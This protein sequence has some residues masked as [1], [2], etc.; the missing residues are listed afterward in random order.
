MVVALSIGAQLA[1]FLKMPQSC[2][3]ARRRNN[4]ALC[5]Y[6]FFED[7]MRISQLRAMVMC[8]ERKW[9]GIVVVLCDRGNGQVYRVSSVFSPILAFQD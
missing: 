7:V 3:T 1:K 6:P 4:K 5:T 2:T 8:V 9:L